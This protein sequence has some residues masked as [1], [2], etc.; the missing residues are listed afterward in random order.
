[1][2]HKTV[3]MVI[4]ETIGKEGGYSNDPQDAGG[5]T[6]WGITEAVARANGYHGAMKDMPRSVAFSIYE[7]EYL[8]K[9][10]FDLILQINED[11]GTEL[12][13]TGVNCGVAVAASF[14][15]RALNLFNEPKEGVFQY[16][17]VVVDG[18]A[19]K[20]TREALQAYLNWRGSQGELVMMRM[21]NAFQAT[22]YAEISER[23]KANER[24]VFGW[25]LH[26]VAI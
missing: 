19:G 8:H 16:P 1:M 7:N 23:R 25:I 2:P 4:D 24:F 10:G 12:F 20:K 11:I 3:A 5:E 26:R 22:R 9:P 15:Q 14:L 18:Q 13:D 6:M 17:E 21:L